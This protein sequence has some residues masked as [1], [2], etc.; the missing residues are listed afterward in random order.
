MRRLLTIVAFA[1]LAMGCGNSSGGDAGDRS[2]QLDRFRKALPQ[3]EVLRA[4]TTTDKSAPKG[5]NHLA[6]WPAVA[7]EE[8]KQINELIT[9]L[10]AVIRDLS[11]GDP[12]VTEDTRL[13]W[14][15]FPA[16]G[17]VGFVFV[18]IREVDAA[19][20]D[21]GYAT[22]PFEFELLRSADETLDASDPVVLDGASDGPERGFLYLDFNG[23]DD[24]EKANDPDWTAAQSLRGSLAAVYEANQPVEGTQDTVSFVAT[25]VR[26]LSS[27]GSTVN[28]S[29]FYGEYVVEGGDSLL[30]FS[31]EG[32]FD[33]TGDGDLETVELNMGHA[34]GA[35]RAEVTVTDG[36]TT[37]T[38]MECWNDA[39]VQTLLIEDWSAADDQSACGDL[40]QSSLAELGIPTVA[41]STS[42]E[43]AECVATSGADAVC[44]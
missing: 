40:W 29:H 2:A 16:D 33:E 37:T 41:D 17:A 18:V 25:D 39:Q 27:D 44:E 30:W 24:F 38:Q 13:V 1:L 15:P 14:G 9:D 23:D 20:A 35:G 3:D 22:L 5:D 26:D 34:L 42:D 28:E 10:V 12:A 7:A 36:G 21:H 43:V 19:E 6:F 31:Y 32:E 11:S 4:R 8:S